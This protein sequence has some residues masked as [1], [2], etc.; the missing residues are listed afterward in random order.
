[1]RA[2]TACISRSGRRNARRVSVV[3]DFNGWDGRRHPMR[4]R[5]DSGLWEIF[6]PG[7]GEG[8]LYKFEIVGADG[9][10]HAAEGRP[11]RLRG[12]AAALDRLGRR[13][14]PNASPGPTATISRAR[15]H[16]D[17]RRAPMSIYEVHLGS[18]RATARATA[19]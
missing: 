6:A 10:A 15:A 3:G 11:V 17:P 8:A 7:I 13:R 4:K 1:M 9:D 12:R 18:W 19:S 5:V 16:G 2:W 14:A